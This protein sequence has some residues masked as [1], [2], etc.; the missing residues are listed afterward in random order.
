M[1]C[2]LCLLYARRVVGKERRWKGIYGGANIYY[3]LPKIESRLKRLTML[4]SLIEKYV[5]IAKHVYL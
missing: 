4:P 1:K 2:L 5:N 3:A